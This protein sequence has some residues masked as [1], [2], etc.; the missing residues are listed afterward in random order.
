MFPPQFPEWLAANQ[1]SLEPAAY[2]AYGK[3][4][5][6]FQKLVNVYETTPDDFPKLME[7]MQDVRAPPR[8]LCV[9]V[10][11]SLRCVGVCRRSYVGDCHIGDG[12]VLMMMC[13]CPCVFLC[14]QL[15]ETG[16]P[17]AEIVKELAPGVP[18]I[19]P[20]APEQFPTPRVCVCVCVQVCACRPGVCPGWIAHFARGR[21]PA[22][23]AMYALPPSAAVCVCLLLTPLC[24]C[25]CVCVCVC[26]QLS[27]GWTATVPSCEDICVC[28]CA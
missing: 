12:H 10:C 13:V 20:T 26:S 8:F 18:A 23:H 6:C 14:A 15:Q 27:Q 2:Q 21:R 7:L 9:S 11:R 5:Q 28:V 1:A 25:V 16:Q 4:F 3:Q 22:R 19:P 17:P 24:V